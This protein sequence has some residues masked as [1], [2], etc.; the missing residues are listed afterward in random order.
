ML[1]E[2]ITLQPLFGNYNDLVR[3]LAQLEDEHQRR[4]TSLE[5][6]VRAAT[7]NKDKSQSFA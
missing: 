1:Y 4:Q 3:R 2:V 5:N 6:E 7:F